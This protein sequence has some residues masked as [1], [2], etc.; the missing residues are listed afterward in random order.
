MP[1]VIKRI[2]IVV[3]Y[4]VPFARL[5]VNRK[6][7]EVNFVAEKMLFERAVNRKYRG[8]VI[9]WITGSPLEIDRED[10]EAVLVFLRL[11]GAAG[12]TQQLAKLPAILLA[13]PVVG[14]DRI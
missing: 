4:H 8:V 6:H 5:R 2:N 10:C 13:I 11:R 7:H 14:E 1:L 3:G 9:S 12:K